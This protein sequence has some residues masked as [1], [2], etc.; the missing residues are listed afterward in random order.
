MIGQTIVH[1]FG[2]ILF[3]HGIILLFSGKLALVYRFVGYICLVWV[4]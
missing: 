4:I 2:T 1:I 3:N